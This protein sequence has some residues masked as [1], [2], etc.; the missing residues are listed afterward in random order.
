MSI[1]WLFSFALLMVGERRTAHLTIILAVQIFARR[2]DREVADPA[3]QCTSRLVAT[4]RAIERA[5][6]ADRQTVVIFDVVA[7]YKVAWFRRSTPRIIAAVAIAAH[8]D[9][10]RFSRGRVV[11]VPSVQ[12]ITACEP[13][14]PRMMLRTKPPRT[15]TRAQSPTLNSPL[16]AIVIISL[17]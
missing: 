7:R 5:F 8:D 13:K 16:G 10:V 1:I 2:T 11:R 4:Q 9:T 14:K 12:S 3:H 17:F 15:F 6:A